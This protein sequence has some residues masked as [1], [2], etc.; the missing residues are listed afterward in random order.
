MPVSLAKEERDL[1]FLPTVNPSP[2]RLTPA[3]IATYNESG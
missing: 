2:R 1:S 3:Q